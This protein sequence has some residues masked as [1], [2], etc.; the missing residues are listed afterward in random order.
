[1]LWISH[2]PVFT[3]ARWSNS[4]NLCLI[5]NSCDGLCSSSWGC[6]LSSLWV[7]PL[8]TL[9]GVTGGRTRA[10]SPRWPVTACLPD[11][12]RGRGTVPPSSLPPSPSFSPCLPLSPHS[13]ARHRGLICRAQLEVEGSALRAAGSSCASSAWAVHPGESSEDCVMECSLAPEGR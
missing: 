1:M 3:P 4:Y 5:R 9:M 12:D 2:R 6:S 7:G 11:A 13:K 8:L 10:W